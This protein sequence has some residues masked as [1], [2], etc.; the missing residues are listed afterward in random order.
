MESVNWADIVEEDDDLQILHEQVDE[1]SITPKATSVPE[2]KEKVSRYTPESG[3][4]RAFV[5]NLPFSAHE[6]DV[7]MFF[8]DHGCSVKQ[9]DFVYDRDSSQFRGFCY[10]EF[11]DRESL[12]KALD[13]N[14]KVRI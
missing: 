10:M 4:F 1:V 7:G 8:Q 3:P 11:S 13:L 5:G 6:N 12:N 9:V 14:N 2:P